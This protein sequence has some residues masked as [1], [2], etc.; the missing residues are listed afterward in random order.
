MTRGLRARMLAAVAFV[1]AAVACTIQLTGGLER[2]ELSTVDARFLLR[3][4]RPAPGNLLV[5]AIDDKTFDALDERWPFSRNRFAKVLEEVSAGD[6][7][8]IVYDVQFTEQSDD[9]RADNRLIEASRSGRQRRLQHDGDGRARGVERVRRPRRARLRPG[10]GRQ[11]PVPRG[12]GRRDPPRAAVDRRARHA[13]RRGGR[14]ARAARADRPHGRPRR[15]DRL[16]RPAAP[17]PAGVV[18]RRRRG[19]GPGRALPRPDRR[20][21]RDGA[22]RS[23][24]PTRCRGPATDVGRRDPR[25]RD[26]HAAARRAP[27]R[28]GRRRRP[29]HRACPRAARAAARAAPASGWPAS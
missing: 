10:G 11:R 6:P 12:R 26:R 23:R 8:V 13:G 28:H 21:R 17:R 2:L 3:G 25:R 27:A 18:L 9:P 5:V 1:A 16:R 29:R 4:E 15:L 20:H 14:A 19:H 7:A 24:T 22:R